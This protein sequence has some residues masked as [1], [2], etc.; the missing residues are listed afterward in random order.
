MLLKLRLWACVCV[1]FSSPSRAVPSTEAS[2]RGGSEDLLLPAG[3]G[4][5]SG[6]LRV[7]EVQPARQRPHPLV[8]L[9]TAWKPNSAFFPCSRF[10]FYFFKGLQRDHFLI[11]FLCSWILKEAVVHGGVWVHASHDAPWAG[12]VLSG[13]PWGA[14]APKPLE[15]KLPAACKSDL[16][17]ICYILAAV[18]SS[19]QMQSCWSAVCKEFLCFLMNFMKEATG[20]LIWFLKCHK[21]GCKWTEISLSNSTWP[22]PQMETKGLGHACMANLV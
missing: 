7:Q 12:Q 16:S 10:I 9:L 17:F 13:Q 15:G 14:R 21:V 4:S 22:E 20:V 18:E 6:R 5:L 8:S 2:G 3:A 11:Y 19:L 1:C